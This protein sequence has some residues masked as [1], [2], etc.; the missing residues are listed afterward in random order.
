MM[1]AKA[2]D[3]LLE[4]KQNRVICYQKGEFLDVDIEDA[5]KMEKGISE[6][7][8]KMAEELSV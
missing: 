3:V 8:V 1:G 4:G 2:V 5:H 6:D 7:M